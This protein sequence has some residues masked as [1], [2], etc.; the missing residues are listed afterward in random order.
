MIGKAKIILK[1]YLILRVMR[2][3]V[4]LLLKILHLVILLSLQS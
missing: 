1:L 3:E 4:K 2:M